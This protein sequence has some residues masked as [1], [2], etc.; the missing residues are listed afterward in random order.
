MAAR[1][2][3]VAQQKGGA[4]KTTLAAHLAVAWARRKMSVAL[5][6]I[7]PQRS[8]AAWHALR[9]EAHPNGADLHLS[10]VAGWRL[11]TELDRLR[12]RFDM[13]VVDTPPHAE[14]EARAA[15]RAGD[16]VL[17]P[18]QPS[19]MDLWATRPTV[20]MAEKEKTT[21]L[22]VL[23]RMP[24]RGRLQEAMLEKLLEEGLPVA[25]TRLGNRVAFAA[26]M[27]EGKGVVE[28]QPR[29]TAAS[30]IN[31]LATEVIATLKGRDKRR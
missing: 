23:N 6:D 12:G 26:S 19:P 1:I 2:I 25:H 22:I 16:M 9:R 4:G 10:D 20:D 11:G 3:T 24:P 17:L 31:A 27:M 13:V 30:E 18:V 14:T 7:D 28:H 21:A 8:L 29:S 5:V 15:V